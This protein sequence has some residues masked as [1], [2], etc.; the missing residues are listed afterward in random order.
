MCK[1]FNVSAVCR[2]GL[3][4]MADI[5]GK[6]AQ[7]KEMADAGQYFTINRARQYGKTTILQAFSKYIEED[8]VVISLDFQLFGEAKFR[9][10][11]IFSLSF[12]KSFLR[13]LK[14]NKIHFNKELDSAL[15]AL[16]DIT[17][18]RPADFELQEL[19]EY[20]SDICASLEKRTVLVIDEVDSA[21]DS[22]VFLDFLSQLRGYYM[23]RER[24]T[25]FHSV[26]LAS[27]YDIKN[28]KRKITGNE[29]HKENSPWNIAADF[30]VSMEFSAKDIETM[31]KDYENDYHTGMDTRSISEMVY[32]YTSGYPF[33][34]SK[35]CKIVDET[36]S[37]MENFTGKNHAWTKEGILEAVKILVNE[38]NTLFESL[39]GKLNEYKE[40]R[41]M[42]YSLLFTGSS[43]FYNPL[44]KYINIAG[45]F[46]FIKN[47]NGNAVIS[48]RI[49]ETVLYNYFLSEEAL[50]NSLYK[51]AFQDKN[52]FIKNGHLDMEL[53]LKKFVIHFNDLFGDREQSF[54]EDEGRRYFLL[55]L[56]PVINGTGNYYI[57][58][59]T[60]NMERTDVIVDYLG[61]QFII[62]MKVW[63]GNSYNTRGEKQLSGYL[64]YYHLEKGYMLSFNFN[65]NK[66]A[67]VK[68]V[69]VGNKVI[70]E[71]V[72]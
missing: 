67:G 37:I 64:D 13:E 32:N 30:L 16:K 66:H 20:L 65:K 12:A 69:I 33:L 19:F 15:A 53:V 48:N 42:V 25:S 45:M 40:L 29:G 38:K 2:P 7:I 18:K 71:A 39:T 61:E 36:V 17:I 23:D 22:K 54:Y 27:V 70:V 49:F 47:V 62:E 14:N 8:Y 31:L 5:S 63:R 46:G 26:I 41:E 34:V 55:Y 3:H 58:S 4:Y 21:A 28:L 10:E 68:E 57:E 11:N 50:N 24:K 43:I 72:V 56:K 52:Q 1:I 9:N 44:N 6:L 35:L 60:R 51:K 59:Q